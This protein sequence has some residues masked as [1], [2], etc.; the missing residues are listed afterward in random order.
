MNCVRRRRAVFKVRLIAIIA[1]SK[2]ALPRLLRRLFGRQYIAELDDMSLPAADY[3][4]PPPAYI[5]AVSRV[6]R[7]THTLH[8]FSPVAGSIFSAYQCDWRMLF[9]TFVLFFRAIVSYFFRFRHGQSK[10]PIERAL[11]PNI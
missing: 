8:T 5:V 10:M 4:P 7:S 3:A 6:H 2:S 11:G 1:R 9:F